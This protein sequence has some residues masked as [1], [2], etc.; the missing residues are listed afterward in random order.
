MPEN[1]AARD[2]NDLPADHPFVGK[3]LTVDGPVSPD[4]LGMTLTHE[5]L[6]LAI[7][8][9]LMTPT[10]AHGTVAGPEDPV[11]LENLWWVNQF[12]SS[13]RDNLLLDDID[14]AVE[15]VRAYVSDGGRSM[16]DVTPQGL[17]NDR[18]D[19]RRI[20]RAA[21]LQLVASTGYYAAHNRPSG[22]AEREI[23][24][25]ADE[26]VR[27]ILDGYPGTD[28]H[29]GIIGEIGIEGPG[30]RGRPRGIAS[31]IELLPGDEKLL[32]ASARAS[33]RSGAAISLHPPA[34]VYRGIGA[35]GAIHGILDIWE[36]EGADLSRVAV[37]HLDRDVWE[38][39]DSMASIAER[40]A[41][42]QYDQW[43]YEGSIH[44]GL[45]WPSDWQ[46]M[47]IMRGLIGEGFGDR[48]LWAHDTCEKRQLR[49]FGGPGY[50]HIPRIVV[51]SMR[52]L[53]VS[54]SAIDT[55]LIDNPARL[56]TIR[57]P[58]GP[59]RNVIA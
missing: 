51:P 20:A 47:Q 42:V 16:V 52:R 35:A 57:P 12:P 40:G 46:R 17:I 4:T 29:A 31:I 37:G 28:L 39:V 34:H 3:V 21:G 49:K 6:L 36:D 26:F 59:M 23:D 1:R 54:Q 13:V 2:R 10:D 14:L 43:G 8:S 58:A 30:R 45:T 15:E 24:D 41:Y 44:L 50:G 27:D 7:A 38:T 32:R 53:G 19:L 18:R 33:R 48:L 25:I 11:T 22:F 55:I 56:L 9:W 5:H